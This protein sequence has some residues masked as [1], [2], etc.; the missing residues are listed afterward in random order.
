MYPRSSVYVGFVSRCAS[1]SGTMSSCKNDFSRT[2]KA[3]NPTS[4]I[5]TMKPGARRSIPKFGKR[6]SNRSSPTAKPEIPK[7]TKNVSRRT[8]WPGF[9]RRMWMMNRYGAYRIRVATANPLT[10]RKY[11]SNEMTV[12][13]VEMTWTGD[14]RI[15]MIVMT[16]MNT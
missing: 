16:M 2:A 7:M 10:N 4:A 13:F 14:T 3:I 11:G 1:A 15:A 5:S 9:V 12:G 6:I 8:S